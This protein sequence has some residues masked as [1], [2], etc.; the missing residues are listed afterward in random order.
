MIHYNLD[1]QKRI[2]HVRPTGALS[3]EDFNELSHVVDPF[4]EETGDL[5]GLILEVAHFPGW[6]D[7]R[8]VARHFRFVR[9]HHKKIKKVAVVTDS[10]IGSAAEHI[11]SHFFPPESSIFLL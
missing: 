1:R 7:L 4:I 8:A 11:A 10:P 6:E 3:K 5:A 9:G 2:L